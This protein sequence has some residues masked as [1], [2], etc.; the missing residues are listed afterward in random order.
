MGP[1]EDSLM[2]FCKIN[3][4]ERWLFR[5]MDGA[6]LGGMTFEWFKAKKDFLFVFYSGQ[7]SKINKMLKTIATI[8]ANSMK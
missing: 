4:G 3:G 2:D 5:R 7:M 8:S 1:D 6:W